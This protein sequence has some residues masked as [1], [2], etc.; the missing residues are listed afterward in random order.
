MNDEIENKETRTKGWTVQTAG[1]VDTLAFFVT[2]GI[3]A[4]YATDSR[5]E[6]L[7]FFGLGFAFLVMYR[8]YV[9]QKSVRD[10]HKAVTASQTHRS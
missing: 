10:M 9:I 7:E 3:V 5:T 2:W 1:F 4:K 6:R 8:L